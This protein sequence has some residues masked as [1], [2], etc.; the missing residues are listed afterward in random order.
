MSNNMDTDVY[1]TSVYSYTKQKEYSV[2][3]NKQYLNKGERVII[4]DDFLAKGGAVMGLKDLIEQSGAI[5]EGVGIVIEKA[6]QEGR[7]ILEANGI[8]IESLVSVK[9]IKDGKIEFN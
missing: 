6:Y 5:L 3:I 7:P 9:A 8:R 1:E 4:I 2:R